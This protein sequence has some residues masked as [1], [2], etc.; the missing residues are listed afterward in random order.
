MLIG[1]HDDKVS[2]FFGKFSRLKF[3]HWQ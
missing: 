3:I 2:Y 1:F